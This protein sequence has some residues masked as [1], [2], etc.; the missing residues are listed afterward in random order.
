MNMMEQLFL[1]NLQKMEMKELKKYRSGKDIKQHIQKVEM[2][3][4]DIKIG[5]T[6]KASCLIE[7]LENRVRNELYTQ[8]DFKDN[9][10][11]YQWIKAKLKDLFKE[12]QSPVNPVIEFLKLKQQPQ[13]KLREFVS[14]IRNKAWK[15]M[16]DEDDEKREELCVM[17]FIK[18]ML[19]KKCSLALEQLKPK[20]LD[21]AYKM[22]KR[23]HSEPQEDEVIRFVSNGDS[24]N[25]E[26]Q[27]AALAKEVR[28]LR[29]LV[30]KLTN[31]Q[32]FRPQNIKNVPA[33]PFT[34]AT[35]IKNHRGFNSAPV[36]EKHPIMCYNCNETGHIA[37]ECRN[38]PVCRYCKE[39]GHLIQNCTKTTKFQPKPIRHFENLENVSEP[40]TMDLLDEDVGINSEENKESFGHL[41]VIEKIKPRVHY[42][43]IVEN[44]SN[45]VNGHCEKPRKSLLE[46]KTVISKSHLEFAANKPIVSCKIK[47]FD[48]NILFDS[49]AENNV[50][51]ASFAQKL[52][53]RILSKAGMMRCANG[54]PL[55]IK[56]YTACCVK[57]G[58]QSINCKFT[59]VDN[60]FPNVIIGLKT[61][62]RENIV[63]N[64][65]KDCIFVKGSQ[66]QFLSKTEI[67]A[68][69]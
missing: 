56:G 3:F 36:K 63:I 19:N 44:W 51:D 15:T 33:R 25:M 24:R 29:I 65:A 26:I 20:T 17:A 1:S 21:E 58:H 28:E 30:L 64:P 31:A 62:K 67:E 32:N 61:M 69:N 14:D 27:M 4:D 49:G 59:V 66:A 5:E 10:K 50:I 46:T 60:I 7:T 2:K 68:E 54:S 57:I 41:A 45:Y 53:L 37:R 48:K 8:P 16:S 22:V 42:P 43:K 40:D 39:S 47:N 6:E 13:Q 11:D 34:Y 52:D 55:A 35:A 38:P 9:K 23:E 18:G 12:K